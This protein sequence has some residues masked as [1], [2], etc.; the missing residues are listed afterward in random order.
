MTNI[1]NLM[2]C[3]FSLWRRE[4]ASDKCHFVVCSSGPAGSEKPKVSN[5]VNVK[6]IAFTR[7]HPEDKWDN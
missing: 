5:A 4:L 3:K 2:F 1:T 6:T 7:K